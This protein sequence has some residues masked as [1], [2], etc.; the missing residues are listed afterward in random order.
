[1]RYTRKVLNIDVLNKC[2]LP[3]QCRIF[4]AEAFSM[5]EQLCSFLETLPPGWLCDAG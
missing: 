2:R 1:M 3:G 5:T 4:S